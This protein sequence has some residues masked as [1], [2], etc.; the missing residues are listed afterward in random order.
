MEDN[1][2]MKKI[3][4][5]SSIASAVSTYVCN[6]HTGDYLWIQVVSHSNI[7]VG[8]NPIIEMMSFYPKKHVFI[9]NLKIHDHFQQCI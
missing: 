5:L 2:Y 8:R 1:P 7:N 4:L 3:P 9:C 6:V